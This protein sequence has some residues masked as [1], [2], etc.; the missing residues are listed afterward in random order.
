MKD[1]LGGKIMKYF[2]GLSA[3]IHSYLIDE[4]SENKNAKVTKNCF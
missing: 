4:G 3:K 2:V 1:D